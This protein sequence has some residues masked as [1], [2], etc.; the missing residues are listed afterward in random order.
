[1]CLFADEDDDDDAHAA[2]DGQLCFPGGTRESL[3]Y[4]R[5]AITHAHAHIHKHHRGGKEHT[6]KLVKLPTPEE[7]TE[8]AEAQVP[9]YSYDCN[10][11]N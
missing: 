6:Q 4:P 11:G 3:Q 2:A 5:E 10:N 9:D 7:W 8:G 1:M